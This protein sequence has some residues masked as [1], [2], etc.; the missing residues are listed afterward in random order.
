[1]K[2][3]RIISKNDKNVIVHL[4]DGEKLF[5]SKEVVLKNGLRKGDQISDDL[6]SFL[7]KENQLFFIKQR[8]YSYLGRRLHSRYELTTKLKSKGY[9]SELI[10]IVLNELEDK[11][12]LNDCEFADAFARDKRKFRRFGSYR[13]K[14]ELI[15]RR[16]NKEI[17][18]Q[19]ISEVFPEG[20][21]ME[22][23]VYHI[24]KKIKNK[25]VDELDDKN[26]KNK[27]IT[28]LIRKGFDFETA[29]NAIEEVKKGVGQ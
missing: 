27:L 29:K 11:N 24:N 22:E 13:I 1:M 4:E 14:N 28:F 15:K 9:E 25:T 21:D 12:Y 18:E 6:S 16:V 7:I 17:I 20:N 2:I 23:A 8:A 26:L 3:E 10:N 5:L 19:V